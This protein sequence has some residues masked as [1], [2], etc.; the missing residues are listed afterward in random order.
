M[1]GSPGRCNAI[2]QVDAPN[3]LM[4][5][6]SRLIGAQVEDIRPRSHRAHRH[7]AT[8]LPAAGQAMPKQ[9]AYAR[10][11]LVERYRQP[12][13]PANSRP[14]D[15]PIV[16]VIL[17][18]SD[19]AGLKCNRIAPLRLHAGGDPEGALLS[20]GADTLCFPGALSIDRLG[21]LYVSD[22]SL[23]VEGNNRLLIFDAESL[24]R[25]NSTTIYRHPAGK[26]F[27]NSAGGVSNLWADR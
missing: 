24:P 26:I 14:A 21:N 18:Q 9:T 16:D 13:S 12:Q 10:P 19:H 22:H 3:F 2:S 17:G 1:V 15:Q 6:P 27:T 7:P 8:L 23:E 20:P 25:T 4:G 11:A 5:D